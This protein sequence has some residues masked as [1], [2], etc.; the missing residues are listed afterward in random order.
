MK[1]F[2]LKLKRAFNFCRTKQ[3]Y[4]SIKEVH[5]DYFILR[6]AHTKYTSELTNTIYPESAHFELGITEEGEEDIK[7]LI[8]VLKEKEINLIIS[9][10]YLRTQMTSKIIAENLDLK[11]NFDK[12]LRDIDLGVYKG[13]SK[14]D[15]YEVITPEKMFYKGPKKGESW[16]ECIKR[17][18]EV[19]KELEEKYENKNILIVSHGDP[20]W[21]LEKGIAK[22]DPVEKLLKEKKTPQPGELRKI[23][24]K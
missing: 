20:L 11:V 18:E 22:K 4:F 10:D 3:K 21:L 9:S 23:T 16:L 12:R 13:K 7:E 19:I 17:T 6:H 24:F 15:F 5:N 2:F 14:D 8:P 1:G